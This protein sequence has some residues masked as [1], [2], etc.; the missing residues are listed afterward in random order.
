MILTPE[1][2]EA[3]I[4]ANCGYGRDNFEQVA[5]AIEREVLRKLRDAGPVAWATRES[6]GRIEDGG[7]GSRGTVPVHANP[8]HVAKF[9][10]FTIPEE[11]T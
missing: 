8:S 2:R 10:L 5:E 3:I 9:P 6:L 4:L 1:E 7:N 11:Q